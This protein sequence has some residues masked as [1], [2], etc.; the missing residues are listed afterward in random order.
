[1]LICPKIET[2]ENILWHLSFKA[3]YSVLALTHNKQ[4]CPTCIPLYQLTEF[5]SSCEVGLGW[6]T[7]W[8]WDCSLY[9]YI[10]SFSNFV[11]AGPV[12]MRP[13]PG[14]CSLHI[15]PQVSKIRH[16]GTLPGPGSCRS[17]QALST[18]CNHK[19]NTSKRKDNEDFSINNALRHP[20]FCHK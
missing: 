8:L 2:E 5:L 12:W 3:Q 11:H 10:W 4:A 14:S 13:C 7:G 18:W 20:H 6:T 17:K 16:L 9:T 15:Q 19:Q 1:M